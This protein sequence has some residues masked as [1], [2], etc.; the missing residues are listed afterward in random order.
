MRSLGVKIFASR[1]TLIK[2]S[3]FLCIL[4]LVSCNA[5]KFVPEGRYLLNR[6]S[7][8]IEDTKAVAA[9]DLDNYL[10]QKQNTEIL[11]FW[12]LQLGLYNT[13]SLDTT[14]WTSR[15]ARKIG[16]PPVVFSPEL[17]DRSVV[18]LQ[19]AMQNKGFFNALVDTT[20]KVK[21]RKL[22]IT[23]TIKAGKPYIIR[24]YYVDIQQKELKQMAIQ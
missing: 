6:A 14:K 16:E 2:L 17:A 23:Y 4:L 5:A 18:Q 1:W 20:M 8:K 9:S 13:A 11:G 12:K 21:D 24:R 22:D 7:V 3:I 15:N 10:Q 19:K